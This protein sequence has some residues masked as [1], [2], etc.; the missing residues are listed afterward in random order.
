[1]NKNILLLRTLLLSTSQINQY[2]YCKD[3]KKR[4]K[5]MW[6]MI[7]LSFLYLLVM[8]YC[9]LMCIGYGAYGIAEAVPALCALTV[10][11]LAFLFTFFKTNGY[12]FNFKEYDMLMSY[13]FKAETVA[14]CKFAY[15]YIKSLP[16]YLSI[17]F[18]MM[19]GY[20]CYAHPSFL[21]YLFWIILSFILPVIPMLISAFLGFL[22]A[23]VSAGF[24]KTNIIQTV[25]MMLVV[26]FGFAIRFIIEDMFRNNKV[27][28]ALEQSMEMTGNAAKVC[29]PAGWFIN[30]VL[31][32]D[33]LSFLLLV[34]VSALLFVLVFMAVGRSYTRINSALKSHAAAKKYRMTALK[35]R[36]P[37]QSVAF[38]EYRRLTGSTTYMVNGAMGEI[39]GILFGLITLVFGFDKIV[40]VVT[41]NAP[42]DHAILQPAIPF[43]IYFFVGMFATTACSPSLEGKNYWIVESLPMKKK[44]LYQGKMLFN[45]YLTV[46]AMV[47]STLCI[48]ISAHVP[49]INTVLYLI[50]GF[51]LCCF[52][53]AWGCVCGVK[54]MR[55][56][57]ENE[58]EVIKQGL[59][60]TVYLLPNMF[61]VMGLTVLVVFLGLKMDHKLLALIFILIASLLAALSYLRVM[62]FARK[63]DSR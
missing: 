33:I 56:D 59:A 57:W 25:L 39:L 1:M 42:F 45:M 4:T 23:R 20:G 8:A 27:Q 5:I 43:I 40:S 55:L 61:V 47:F 51:A 54:H 16:W 21:T 58:I 31:K 11:L 24:R 7:G 34:G 22:I 18:A 15:M 48:C 36:S 46:P 62:S 38:K 44:S 26:I 60:V 29:F 9:I 37:V 30:A 50:L 52:S 2:R 6:G 28:S 3:K 17:S 32:Q 19:I 49:L 63:A 14:A 12:L 10:S 41:A 53:T 13:P 35:K